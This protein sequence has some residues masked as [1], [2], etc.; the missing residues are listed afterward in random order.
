LPIVQLNAPCRRFQI[1]RLVHRIA[2][3]FQIIIIIIIIVVVSVVWCDRN[4][5]I[6]GGMRIRG[7]KVI[8]DGPNCPHLEETVSVCKCIQLM[9]NV[10]IRFFVILGVL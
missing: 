3:R 1:G 2:V 9:F 10:L 4:P 6:V 8:E 5:L 7:R